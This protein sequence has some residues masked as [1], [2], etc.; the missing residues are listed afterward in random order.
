MRYH[1]LSNTT[2]DI[3]VIGLGTWP[4]SGGY[5]WGNSH[6][7]DVPSILS[8]AQESGINFIDTA[9]IYDGS[10]LSLGSALTGRRHQFVLASKCGLCKKDLWPV[11][12]LRPVSI[13]NQ[14]EESLRRLKTDYIDLYQ[15]HYP[16]PS[17]ALEDALDVLVRAKEQGKVRAV[18]ICNAT[19][20]QVAQCSR[21]ISSVQNEYSL[22]HPQAGKSVFQICEKEK[23]SL[24]GYGTLCGGILSGKYQRE[25][26]FRRADARNYFYKCYRH[27]AFEKAQKTVQKVT[28]VAH[29]KQTSPCAVAISWALAHP[30]LASVLV[31][32]K[33]TA[34][35]LQNALGGDLHLS[36]EELA[37]LEQP[38]E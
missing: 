15:I 21:F 10:E 23:L 36:S 26:N 25:P 32:A 20:E 2:F 12:D 11:H 17:V 22:L 13:L 30:Q 35:V 31:G 29:Q 5:D 24:I 37:Y 27:Q 1:R 9:P 7:P 38:Y 3:S 14:L 34:Q 16:D 18:G 28:Q 19:A 33:T 8:A 4:F 6:L